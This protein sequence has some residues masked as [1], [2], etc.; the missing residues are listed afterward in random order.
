MGVRA[1]IANNVAVRGGINEVTV[2]DTPATGEVLTATGSTTASWQPGGGGG[3]AVTSVDGDIGDVDLSGTYV[4]KAV[5]SDFTGYYTPTPFTLPANNTGGTVSGLDLA[6][7]PSPHV[8][9]DVGGQFV[10]VV[11][12]GLYSIGLNLQPGA[13]VPANAVVGG[14]CFMQSGGAIPSVSLGPLTPTSVNGGTSLAVAYLVEG[15]HIG[16]ISVW[17]RGLSDTLDIYANLD[18]T[19]IG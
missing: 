8:A 14:W 6:F 4:A 7:D 17:S 13:A 5:A 12:D 9:L 3:G 16:G 18:I 1:W 11:D 15:N 10:L 19:K 2:T